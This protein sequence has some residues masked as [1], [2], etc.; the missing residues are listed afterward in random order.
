MAVLLQNRP[1]S[2]PRANVRSAAEPFPDD[3]Y[4]TVS[5]VPVFAEHETKSR[6]GRTLRFSR[7]ELEAVANR[8]NQRIA[9]TGDYATVCVGHTSDPGD[10][11][12]REPRV[13]GAAGPFRVGLLGE[14]GHRQ[15]YCILADFH[16]KRDRLSDYESHPRR[17]PELWLEDSYDE[18]FLD[19]ISLLGAE[20]P[21]LDMGLA[22]IVDA[23]G[24]DG[25]FTHLYSAMRQGRLREKY[26][27]AG[28]ATANVFVPAAEPE[29]QRRQ[30]AAD[31][32]QKP[33]TK[34]EPH[35]MLA[36]E[37]IKQI[38]DAIEQLDWVA[39]VKEL[40][41]TEQA[42][43]QAAELPPVPGEVAPSEP[44]LATPEPPPTPPVPPVEPALDAAPPVPGEA[45]PPVPPA[46]PEKEKNAMAG[47]GAPPTTPPK[48]YAADVGETG[49]S[50]DEKGNPEV[51]IKD[52]S[53]DE[54]E[55]YLCDRRKKKYAAEQE[56]ETPPAGE[57]NKARYSQLDS[58]LAE[59]EADRALRID[60]ARSAKLEQ[61][62]YHRVFDF[63][64]EVERCKYAKMPND[65]A[66]VE[67]CTTIAENYIPT[68]ANAPMPVPDELLDAKPA[69]TPPKRERYSKDV[70]DKAASYCYQ[71]SLIGKAVDYATVLDIFAA[72]KTPE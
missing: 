6:D 43:H 66:F 50:K 37:D 47:V 68:L 34:K 57:E 69:A 20:A 46:E 36:P 42:E 25:A 41:A 56:A 71:Q 18:M 24:D 45:P 8:C 49:K 26:A 60:Q 1:T 5:N 58:R 13:I 59:L 61:L 33:Q 14:P 9:E 3:Q 39:A 27:A 31:S 2:L 7:P 35:L 10:S 54:I 44:P 29:G 55:K 40:L 52:L 12:Q 62:R 15:R 28:P 4:V 63:N 11:V 23:K 67:H 53:D 48:K 38:V 30:Y 16:I 22:P 19:P 72:G 32:T 51:K 65:V 17:S 21:R 64:K 70:A